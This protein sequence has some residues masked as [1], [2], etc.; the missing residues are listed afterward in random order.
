MNRPD[1]D[2]RAALDAATQAAVPQFAH[3]RLLDFALHLADLAD[4]L[5]AGD[6]AA[7]AEAAEALRYFASQRYD[8]AHHADRIV[9]D[10]LDELL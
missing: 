6:P 10:V 3:M 1:R 5:D 2:R 7:T 8:V 9:F 4:R